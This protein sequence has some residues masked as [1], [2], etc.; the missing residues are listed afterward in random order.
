MIVESVVT[1]EFPLD[2]DYTLLTCDYYTL[3]PFHI[4]LVVILSSTLYALQHFLEISLTTKLR[5]FLNN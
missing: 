2:I 4:L 1:L 5:E 3:L